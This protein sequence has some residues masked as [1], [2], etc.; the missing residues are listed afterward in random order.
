[1]VKLFL[2]IIKH[3]EMK[4]YGGLKVHLHVFLTSALDKSEFSDSLA[5]RFISELLISLRYENV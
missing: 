3:Q 2:G 5:G 4:M 1:M